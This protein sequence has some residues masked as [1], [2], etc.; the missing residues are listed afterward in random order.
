MDV[1]GARELLG[2][3]LLG[4]TRRADAAEGGGTRRVEAGEGAGG[5]A[6]RDEG[7]G[8][9]RGGGGMEVGVCCRDFLLAGVRV[10]E[11]GGD[12]LVADIVGEFGKGLD[13]GAEWSFK[14]FE[15]AAQGL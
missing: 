3:R 10:P 14:D 8:G 7:F 11:T 15:A 4:G 2:E 5:G 6:R 1:V 13:G 9:G 12:T